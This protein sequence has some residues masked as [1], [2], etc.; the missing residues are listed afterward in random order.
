MAASR[1]TML[2]RLGCAAFCYFFTGAET[3]ILL[4]LFNS[5]CN[6]ANWP[7]HVANAPTAVHCSGTRVHWEA[8]RLRT[9][10]FPNRMWWWGGRGTATIGSPGC[11]SDGASARRWPSL[12]PTAAC[13]ST[14]MSRCATWWNVHHI[15]LYGRWGYRTSFLHRLSPGLHPVF[16][17][18]SVTSVTDQAASRA[19]GSYGVLLC[20]DPKTICSSVQVA[21]QYLQFLLGQRKFADAAARC[22]EL[23]KVRIFL[24]SICKMSAMCSVLTK[25]APSTRMCMH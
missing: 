9:T 21:M 2:S 24:A 16:S 20:F 23:L 6:C 8:F 4:R 18:R 11:C 7:A 1:C 10:P 14:S 12:P 25:K 5:L 19:A 15:D 3:R 22:P 17:Q 13:A